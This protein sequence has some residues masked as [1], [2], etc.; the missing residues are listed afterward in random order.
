MVTVA[1]APAEAAVGGQ[2]EPAGGQAEPAGAPT[3]VGPRPPPPAGKDGLAELRRVMSTA[4]VPA[5]TYDSTVQQYSGVAE[6]K[7]RDYLASLLATYR[8]P[9]L[10]FT[11]KERQPLERL[12]QVFLGMEAKGG[13]TVEERRRVY[14]AAVGDVDKNTSYPAKDRPF[15]KRMAIL[16]LIRTYAS[17]PSTVLR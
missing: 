6:D 14:D 5:S 2:A 11:A 8:K 17:D 7:R 3:V 13:L 15:Y 1:A 12:K 4:K 16:N 10:Q 9:A